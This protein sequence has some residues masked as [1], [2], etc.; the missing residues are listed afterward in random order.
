MNVLVIDDEAGVR[1]TVSMILE[2]EGYRVSTASNGREGLE[3]A[4]EDDTDIVLCDVRMPE[5]DGLEFLDKYREGGG[6]GLV[7]A[8]TAY[9][10]MD[11]A[12]EAMQRGAYDY[13]AKPFSADAILLTIRKAE[14]REKLRREVTRLRRQ[15]R[16]EKRHPEM[17]VKSA[18][19]IAA[20]ELAE[21]VAPHPSTVL[22][23]GESGT[24]KEVI[25]RLIHDSSSRADGPFVP[26]NCGAIPENLLEA[27]LFG[28]VKGAFTGA[29]SNRVGLFEE[30]N[31]GT[32]FLDEIGELPVLLQVKLL[33]ALQDR[34]IRR[35]GESASRQVDV[36]I[37]AATARDLAREVESGGFR[38]DLFYRLNV[39]NIHLPPLRHR[40]EDIPPLVRHF[41][42]AYNR[43]LGTNVSGFDS[44]AMNV[45]LSYGWPG[46]VRELENVVERAMVLAEQEKITPEQLPPTL[47]D[48]AHAALKGVE[49]LPEDELSVKKRTA[50][51]ESHLIR[52][53]LE[54]TGGNRTRASALLDLSYRALLYKI[55]DYGLGD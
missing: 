21:K 8:M 11:V 25:A 44:K 41:V 38:S 2:D 34:E 49:A 35:V 3:H 40:S 43:T 50:E 39:V 24:G 48:K 4:L 36:R 42:A 18:P 22:V 46:N 15:V 30:A 53:A 54:I 47:T 19:M 7:L 32:L 23:T 14:E 12:L 10:G 27:E 1:R 51:L 16:T 6:E 28:H 33:R 52:R 17:V 55:R 26:V 45:L 31:G 9:G 13:I 29:D 37:V 5:M 20:V